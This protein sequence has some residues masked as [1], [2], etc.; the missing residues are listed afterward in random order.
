MKKKRIYLILILVALV[1]ASICI[2]IINKKIRI[3]P[4]FAGG[5]EVRGVDVSHYQGTID[6]EKLAGQELDFAFIKATEGSSHVD[7]CFADNWQEA[8]KT[9]L[10][11]GAY[12]FFSFDSDGE[13][14]AELY[15]DTVGSLEGKI[16]PVVD[17]EFYGDKESNPPQKDDVVGELR[18]ML[19]AL[20]EYYQVKPI[21]YTTYKAYHGYIKGGFD[22]YPLWIRNVYYQP[23]FT[24]GNKWTF[25]QYT[26]TAVLEGY[27]GTEKYIDM[28][29]FRGTREELGMLTVPGE[30]AESSLEEGR[31]DDADNFLPGNEEESIEKKIKKEF[32]AGHC[33]LVYDAGQVQVYSYLGM[34]SALYVLTPESENVIY[35]VQN[36][37]ADQEQEAVWILENN[38]EFQIRKM[39]LR[40]DHFLEDILIIDEKEMETLISDTYGLCKEEDQTAFW[41]WHAVLS[42]KGEKG[43]AFLG[44]TMS[45]VY[46]E[47]G[48]EFE[49]VYEIDRKSGKISAKGYLQDLAIH[50]LYQEFLCNNLTVEN[51]FTENETELGKNLSFFDDEIYLSK[52]GGFQKLFAA[53]DID[54]DG[55]DELIFRLMQAAGREE[56]VYVLAEEKDGLDCRDILRTNS[57]GDLDNREETDN[58]KKSTINWFDCASFIE[59][60]TERC[61]DY[62]S[63]EE[64]FDAIEEG[65]FSVVTRKDSD[66]D[67]MIEELEMAYKSDGD[68]RRTEQCDIDRDGFD[69]LLLL[70]QYE[71]ED[72]ERIDFILD[73]RNGRAVCTY[74]DWCDGNE[75]LFLG[76]KGK[77]IHCSS[78]NNSEYDYYG[79]MEC[80]LNARGIKDIDYTGYG[81]EVFGVYGSV[82]SGLWWWEGQRPEI[83][84]RGIYF[85]E[86]RP[87]NE[88]EIED[89]GTAGGWIKELTSKEQFLEEYKELTG[90]DFVL[91]VDLK[92]A[93]IDTAGISF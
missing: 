27:Q 70:I 78:S 68:S 69:E 49:I 93:N 3:T 48:K 35:P 13:K 86:V 53:A 58:F 9:D 6:W 92:K 29:V 63:R 79:F 24:A 88:E 83:T 50:P 80:T 18:K 2:F 76:D 75:W 71:F 5:F 41:D 7:E 38:E 82:E 60:P 52:S 84:Q 11:I 42:D 73:Y 30:G 87:K 64:V 45:G 66:P 62:K 43:Q 44:G 34:Q 10:Y 36:F 74:F 40:Q 37:W 15:I 25:W 59:I 57:V 20:E 65:D 47:T 28:N 51:P 8:G 81:I 4:I 61:K 16:A 19:E 1:I 54:E 21:I 31:M 90:E 12:H 89:T 56:L 46:K 17:V 14:Q 72:Y 55:R 32:A 23:L 67:I 85:A 26:D 77:L 33:N 39:D 22:E 91:R